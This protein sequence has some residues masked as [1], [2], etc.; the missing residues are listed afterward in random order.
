MKK[1]TINI[2]KL[3]APS[4]K[5]YKVKTINKRAFFLSSGK[6]K[7]SMALEGS[8]VLPIFLFFMMTILL[9][10]EA[11]RFQS[12]VQ[13]AL[14]L[15]GSRSAFLEYQVKYAGSTRE[16]VQ[17]QVKEYLGSQLYPYLCVKEENIRWQDLSTSS[18]GGILYQVSYS[19]KPF[20][21]WIPIGDIKITDRFVSHA[22]TGYCGVQAWEKDKQQDT[23]VYIT[24][25]GSKYHLSHEC[26]YL[27]VKIQAVSYEK[28]VTLRNQ[29][30][31]KYYAC[32]RCRPFKEGVVYITSDGSS[33]H[34]QADCS[35]LKRTVYM[36]PLSEADQY[37]PCSKCTG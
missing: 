28:A 22:W 15:A 8:L 20:I 2:Q 13:E 32:L 24:D 14:Y 29:S 23:Y 12:E 33:F 16:D 5:V 3:K 11:V 36:I 26:T 10:L 21:G 4:L 19:L 27:R 17:L 35:S 7:A 18:D 1:V 34:G 9:G 31:G 25:T 37:S 6:S 30:G